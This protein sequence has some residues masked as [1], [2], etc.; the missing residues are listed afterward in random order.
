MRVAV[1]D[2]EQCFIKYF[3]GIMDRMYNSLDIITDEFS[4]GEEL[5]K[6]FKFKAYDVVFLDIEMPDM[7]GITLA[8]K[9]RELSAEVC[10]V[11][12]TGHIE[13]A[14]KG[15]EVNALRYLTKPA[16]EKKVK[17][18]IDYVL[19]K[20]EGVKSI[21]VKTNDG[22]QKVALADIIFIEAQN[23]NVVIN[24]VKGSY[25][26]R[27]NISDY[28][29]ELTPHGFFR[30]HRG[31]LISLSKVLRI[32]SKSVVMEDNSDLPVSRSKESKLRETLFSYVSGEAF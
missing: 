6:A 5:L 28:E 3:R 24:T 11:F 10:I 26:V 4:G 9:L 15:Y 17:E 27:G 2:D 22:A 25:S 19:S 30:I 31:Y 16:D 32:G 18:V 29:V 23:Q 7:D 1:C 20:Q 8:R 13:Y 14:I 21:W 12:L